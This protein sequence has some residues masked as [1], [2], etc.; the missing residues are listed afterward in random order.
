[1]R[2]NDQDMMM[3][4]MMMTLVICLSSTIILL[5]FRSPFVKWEYFFFLFLGLI[6]GGLTYV[7]LIIFQKWFLFVRPYT[8]KYPIKTAAAAGAF[9]ALM[10]MIMLSISHHHHH[11][12]LLIIYIF[13]ILS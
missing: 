7:Y 11:R 6:S 13:I 9:T 12:A 8:T 1:M 5:F 2:Y 10:V 3:M 4:M